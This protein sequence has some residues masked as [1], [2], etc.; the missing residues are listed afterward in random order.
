[1]FTAENAITIDRPVAEVFAYATDP[2]RL[3]EWRP[4]VIEVIGYQPPMHAGT[5]YELAEKM[6]GRQQFGQQVTAYEPDRLVVIETTSGSVRPI[7][8]YDFEPT[9]GGGTRFIT[10]LEIRTYG[11]MRIFEPLMRGRV[12]K[13]MVTY[14]ENLKRNIESMPRSDEAAAQPAS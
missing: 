4:N 9:P 1:M 12:R 5:S 3:S 2:I 6:M 13:T 14:G 7:Q 10:H 8:R 11:V